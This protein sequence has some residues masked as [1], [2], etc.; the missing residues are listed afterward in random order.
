MT[1]LELTASAVKPSQASRASMSGANRAPEAAKAEG[2]LVTNTESTY[3]SKPQTTLQAPSLLAFESYTPISRRYILQSISKE[4]LGCCSAGSGDGK[5]PFFYRL[6]ACQQLSSSYRPDSRFEESL[7]HALSYSSNGDYSRLHEVFADNFAAG[8][9]VKIDNGISKVQMSGLCSCDSNWICP[10]CQ[11][12]V[13]EYRAKELAYAVHQ[14]Q[15]NGG[16]CLFVTFTVPHSKNDSL[17]SIIEGLTKSLTRFKSGSPFKLFKKRHDYIGSVRSLE[18]TY[19]DKNGHHP[20]IHELWFLDS[21]P[22]VKTVKDWVYKTY[23]KLVLK[24]LGQAPSYRHGVDV[25]LV[26]TDS[27]IQNI[28]DGVNLNDAVAMSAYITKGVDVDRSSIDFV[29]NRDWS[30]ADEMTKANYKR[31]RKYKDGSLITSFNAVTLL[32]EYMQ[33]QYL[34]DTT[35]NKAFLKDMARLRAIYNDY[36]HCTFGRAAL[37]WSRGLKD[38]FGVYD[39]DDQLLINEHDS[40]FYQ[41]MSFDLDQLQ[42][43]IKNRLRARLCTVAAHPDL[44]TDEQRKSAVL[45]ELDKIKTSGR[46]DR[47]G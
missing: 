14:H 25:R 33:L 13:S 36:A 3:T 43:I 27:Q 2:R 38:R 42:F 26:A 17:K 22:D 5:R 32:L 6:G 10:V 24:H 4:L 39:L 29:K 47:F 15:V 8:M 9:S 35:G 11:P 7:G 16:Y 12:K 31:S 19:T 23:S 1:I 40:Q 30:I 20:H 44:K 34:V 21:M 18:W 45:N 37:F 41:F 28:F 46:V